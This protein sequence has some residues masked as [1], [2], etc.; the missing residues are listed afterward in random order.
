[1]L[2]LVGHLLLQDLTVCVVQLGD[3]VNACRALGNQRAF[4]EVRQNV[5]ELIVLCELLYIG[6]QLILGDTDERIL[7]PR[8][9]LEVI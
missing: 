9:G 8:L 4:D 7:D 5:L 2:P 1:M 3:V 6:N